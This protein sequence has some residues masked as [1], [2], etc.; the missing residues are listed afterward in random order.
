M[1]PEPVRYRNL[2]RQRRTPTRVPLK[3]RDRVL[4][5]VSLVAVVLVVAGVLWALLG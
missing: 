3:P 5:G 1:R 4:L 2:A